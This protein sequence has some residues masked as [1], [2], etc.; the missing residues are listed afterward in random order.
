MRIS[1]LLLMLSLLTPLSY[2]APTTAPVRVEIDALLARLQSS[3]CKFYRNGQ[4]FSA[5]RAKRHLLSKLENAEDVTTLDNTEEFIALVATKSSASGRPYQVRCADGAVRSSA[6]WLN[7][8]LAAMR[9][10]ATQ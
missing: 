5:A 3:E 9:A 2:A 10:E 4:W 6:E 7:A 8:E 1:A